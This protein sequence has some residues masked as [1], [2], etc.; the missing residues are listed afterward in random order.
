MS[1]RGGVLDHLVV[2]LLDQVPP[3]R[4]SQRRRQPRVRLRLAGRWAIEADLVDL[5]DPRQEVEAEQPGDAEPDLGLAVGVD[6]VALNLHRG[7]VP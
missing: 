4:P 7:A 1:D 3:D 2:V 5:F 6:V